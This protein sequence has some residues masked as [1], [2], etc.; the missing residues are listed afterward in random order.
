MVLP[1]DQAISFLGTNPDAVPPYHKNNFSIMFI[2]ALFVI[3]RNWKQPRS[4]SIEEWMKKNVAHLH[5][6]ILLSD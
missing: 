5:N 4:P 6:G 2:A 3:T 1:E